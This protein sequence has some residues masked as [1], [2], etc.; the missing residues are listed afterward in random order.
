MARRGRQ[1][2]YAA[3]QCRHALLEHV[4]RRV[5][6]AGIDVPEFF[7]RKQVGT[8]FGVVESVGGRLVNR[9]G[10]GLSR[11]VGLLAGVQLEGFEMLGGFLGHGLVV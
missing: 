3:F 7:Q 5:H 1:S 4:G 8:V 2:R 10:A 11:R 6:N 9:H